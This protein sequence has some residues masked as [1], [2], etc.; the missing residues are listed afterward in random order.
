MCGESLQ[1]SHFDGLTHKISIF[2][3]HQYKSFFSS[4]VGES[5]QRCLGYLRFV[6]KW[7]VIHF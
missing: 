7:V 5:Q 3:T 1:I 4:D 2:F 6:N